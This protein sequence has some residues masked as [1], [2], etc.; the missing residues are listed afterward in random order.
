MIAFRIHDEFGRSGRG[1]GQPF[2]L[3]RRD[4]FVLGADNDQQRAR[5][6]FCRPHERDLVG[7]PLRFLR[8]AGVSAD[9]PGFP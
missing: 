9:P 2:T 1:L 8:A 7:D 5:D 3:R 4:Q 6:P